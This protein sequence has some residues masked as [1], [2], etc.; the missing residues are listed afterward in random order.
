[1]QILATMP[2]NTAKYVNT[3]L[4]LLSQELQMFRKAQVHQQ[5]MKLIRLTKKTVGNDNY[6]EREIYLI[7]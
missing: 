7:N 2:M 4:H 1:M 5:L 6:F 3:S